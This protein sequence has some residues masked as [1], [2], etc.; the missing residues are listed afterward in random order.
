MKL[1]TQMLLAGVLTLIVPIV[2]WHSVK[3]LYAA[4]QQTRI[5]EQSLTTLNLRVAIEESEELDNVFVQG[6]R[7]AQSG[8]WYAETSPYPIFIDGYSD[9]WRTLTSPP[10]EFRDAGDSRL[11]HVRVAR[12]QRRLFIY[13]EIRDDTVVYHEP[14]L[15]PVNP[16]EGEIPDAASRL[17]N[18]D[19]VEIL[20]GRPDGVWQHGLFRAIAP[21]PVTALRASPSRLANGRERE[22]GQPLSSWRGVWIK[23]SRGYQLEILYN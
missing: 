8:D 3:Q 15:M 5:D 16:G 10:L 4:L 6:A 20:I 23:N 22:L 21:G 12:Y 13:A 2:G 14:P 9:D 11:M 17:V 7:S 18:G 1:R 19:A